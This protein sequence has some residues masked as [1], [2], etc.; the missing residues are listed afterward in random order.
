MSAKTLLRSFAGGEITPELYG[1]LDLTKYQ[2]GLSKA[3]NF[4]VLPH[5]PAAR[6]PGFRFINEAKDSTKRV[7]LIPFAYSADQTV[8]LE[9][10]DQ[11]IRFHVNGSTLLEPTVA[12][13]SVVGNVVT[14]TAAHGYST[15]DWVYMAAL[16]GN[17][18]RFFKIT[19][20]GANTFT[21][22]DYWGVNTNPGLANY[23]A[24]RVYTLTTPYIESDLFELRYAQNSDVITI[25]HPDYAARELSR[26]SATSW[27]LSTINFVPT[28]P[29]PA[30][31]TVTATIAQNQN[32]SPQTY[33]V[34]AVAADGVT[35]SLASSPTTVNNNLT[36]AGNYNTITFNAV[37]GGARYNIYRKRGGIYGYIGQIR[38]T[39]AGGVTALSTLVRGQVLSK[40]RTVTVTT[41]AAHGRT[42]G[43]IVRIYDTGVPSF[44]GVWVIT[45]INTTTFIYTSDVASNFTVSNTGNMALTSLGIVDDNILPDTGRT[46][47][48][49]IVY[50]NTNVNDYPTTVTYYEQRRWFAGTNNAQ[51]S[52]WATRN[53]TETNLTSSVP[54]QEDDALL[55]RIASQQ[56]NAI[57]HLVPLSDLIA[58]TIGGEFRIFA[59]NAPNITPTSLSIKPQGYTGASSVQPAL[60]SGSIL[61]V[62]SQG[63]RIREFSYNSAGNSYVSIDISIMAPH[64]FNGYTIVDLAFARAPTPTLWAVR[65]DG[66]LLGMTYV[67][68]QQVYG[69]HQHTTDG[70]FESV[71]V[72]G[73][74]DEDVLYAVVRR[75]V[76]NRSV[77]YIERLTSE[78]LVDQENAFFVDSGL[79]YEDYSGPP[80]STISGLY[81]LEGKSV[82]VLANGAVHPA[83]TVTNGAITLDTPANKVQI[84]LGYNS[85]LQTLPLAF[86]GA[87]AGG[88]GFTKN[89]NKVAMR[90]TNS[91][92]VKAGPSFAKL[93]EYPARDVTDP[94]GSPPT[95]KTGE[96]RF[97]VGPSWNS[98]GMIC[99]RQD[100]PLPLTIMSMALDVATGG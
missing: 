80:A 26:T 27:T 82:Q 49:N 10:G 67:P 77:R 61:Y 35:E 21:T 31:P 73:E 68:E 45:V 100:Q 1:R 50:L 47:P 4:R 71:S 76:N 44:D 19:V 41:A 32:L 7:R 16:S 24:A 40:S 3:L 23:T 51:Q 11:Y 88:Q 39:N 64:L 60:T 96:L 93:T 15:G 52:I 86:D 65:S 92:L 43:D 22:Q 75:T 18:A 12:I 5:G 89:I 57:Q 58:L 53:G 13:T 78:I 30:A 42:T 25:T 95:L 97:A 83:R 54:T 33:V 87:P 6:R 2:T 69:W 46:P 59:D 94:Y 34:T 91:S 98:D 63:S 20:T 85:D 38:P 48:E 17:P 84:G 28:F 8:L 99:V 81:H 37:D 72:I 79:T 14:T 74:G 90:V 36:L 70:F 62:Q 29:V 66:V 9:F 56:Q 55:F